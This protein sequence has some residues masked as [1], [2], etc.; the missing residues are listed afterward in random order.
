MTDAAR[1]LRFVEKFTWRKDREEEEKENEVGHHTTRMRHS[2]SLTYLDA[3]ETA[4]WR[5]K[6]NRSRTKRLHR[7]ARCRQSEIGGF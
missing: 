2:S 5:D 7:T 3:A 6:E 4:D 1:R